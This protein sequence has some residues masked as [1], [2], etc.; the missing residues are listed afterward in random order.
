[1]VYEKQEYFI[2]LLL[3]KNTSFFEH[4][5]DVHKLSILSPLVMPRG[6]VQPS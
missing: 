3:G 5:S 4:V 2:I 6:S 1:M